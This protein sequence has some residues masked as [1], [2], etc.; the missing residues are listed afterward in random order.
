MYWQYIVNQL[1][2]NICLLRDLK[3]DSIYYLQKY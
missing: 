1:S 3:C 2:L